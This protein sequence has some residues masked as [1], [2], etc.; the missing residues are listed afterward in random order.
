MVRVEH[1]G[2]T[3]QRSDGSNVVGGSGCSGNG[4]FLVSVGKTFTT[5]KGGSTLGN[6]EDDG[7][8]DVSGSLE[9]GV[10]DG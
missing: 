2:D 6:L 7:G 1:N 5:E 8:V 3:V 4:G 10:D 9:N